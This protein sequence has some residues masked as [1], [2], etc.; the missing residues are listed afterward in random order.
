MGPT[1]SGKTGIAVALKKRK[2]KVDIIS[3]DSALVYRGMDIGTAKPVAEELKIAPHKLIDI[4]DPHESYSLADFYC[5]AKKEFEKIMQDGRIPVFVGG[6]MLYFKTLLQGL[7]FLPKADNSIRQDIRNEAEKFGWV[8]IY[9]K[10]RRIDPISANIIHVN[11][12][13]RITRALE[14]FLIS[15]K[16]WTELKLISDYTLKDRIYQFAIMPSCREILNKRIEQRFHKMLE[17]GFEHEVSLLFSRPELHKS[18]QSSILCVG[19]RQMWEYLSG[20]IS[21]NYMITTAIRATHRLAKRQL[22]WLR[23]WPDLHW[24]NSDNLPDAIDSIAEI[25]IKKFV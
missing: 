8:S 11:D 12:H 4:R 9:N 3:V 25:L 19:Y 15:G 6:T 18:V 10:L 14:I 7:F 5:D 13:K 24:L 17:I 1:A 2:H 23:K 16:T 20:S 22:T 21:Y